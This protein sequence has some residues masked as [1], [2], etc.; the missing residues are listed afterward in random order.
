M[1]NNGNY[2]SAKIID[3]QIKKSLIT[4]HQEQECKSQIKI[5]PVTGNKLPPPP[6]HLHNLNV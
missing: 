3:H 1:E 2:K 5:S 4:V 6:P